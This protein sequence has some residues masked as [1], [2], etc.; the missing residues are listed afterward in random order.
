MAHAG[1]FG[2]THD[3]LLPSPP[4]GNGAGA[5]LSVLVHGALLL[6]LT[7]AVQWRSRSSD[8]VSAELWSAVPQ[9]AGSPA[10]P[11]AAPAPPPAP[12]PAPAPAPVAAPPA[13]ARHAESPQPE[14]DIAIERAA[15]RKAELAKE[16]KAKEAR[17][18]TEEEAKA[19]A[20]RDRV[21]AEK[22]KQADAD[23]RQREKESRQ[24]K[25]EEARLAQQ[26]E[27]TLARMMGEAGKATGTGTGSGSGTSTGAGSSAHDAGP[28][29]AYAGRLAALIRRNSRF[30]G[31]LPD[32]SATEVEVITA[33][34]GTIISRR[35]VKSSG[36]PEW[37]DAVVRAIDR[38]GRLPP[39]ERG[40]VP[41][42][43]TIDFRPNDR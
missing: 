29:A 33:P 43:L 6:A 27:Q 25:A 17:L 23:R 3:A 26:R 20:E 5:V 41:S 37:D 12:A 36:H 11:A 19:Q 32:N 35:I 34:G 16:Q 18:K 4:G 8:V 39:D 15:R 22:K 2:R 30:A 21:A 24:A 7:T 31:S 28:S 9:V 40:I 10:P 14:P 38:T 13:P 1:S 42:P